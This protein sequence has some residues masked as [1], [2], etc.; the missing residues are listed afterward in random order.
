MISP[1]LIFTYDVLELY[2]YKHSKI[3]VFY[4]I[5]FIFAGD[6]ANIARYVPA[7]YIWLSGVIRV[8]IRVIILFVWKFML[9]FVRYFQFL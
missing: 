2:N 8:N 1:S 9:I 4:S 5:S 6:I 3:V 7:H